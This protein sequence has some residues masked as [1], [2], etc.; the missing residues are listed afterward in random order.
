MATLVAHGGA[1]ARFCHWCG[2]SWGDAQL[3]G[4]TAGRRLG[5]RPFSRCV[6][7]ARTA[8]ALAAIGKPN[9]HGIF[10]APDHAAHATI[11]KR[12]PQPELIRDG[13]RPHPR[14][15][16]AATGK[17]TQDARPLQMSVRIVDRCRQIPFDPE[18]SA[19][20][21]SH[22]RVRLLWHLP[23]VRIPHLTTVVRVT[24][25]FCVGAE[26]QFRLKNRG[27]SFDAVAVMRSE[28]GV[29]ITA[30][31]LAASGIKP[32][33]SCRPVVPAYRGVI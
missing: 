20:V 17:I 16:C 9:A 4:S 27:S 14:E 22:S 8:I 15:V 33:M 24:H 31:L 32:A 10:G 18:V 26:E 3:T 23:S 21:E 12:G 1:T 5:V 25:F 29:E 11:A 30:A 2:I 6:L 28:D 19:S 7:A 13:A